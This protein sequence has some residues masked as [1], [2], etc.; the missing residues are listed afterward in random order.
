MDECKEDSCKLMLAGDG[1]LPL[2]EN[3]SVV[4][5]VVAFGIVRRISPLN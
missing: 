4:V 1:M 5:G 3:N 2:S